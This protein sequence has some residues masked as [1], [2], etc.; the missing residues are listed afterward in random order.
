MA[1]DRGVWI[2]RFLRLAIA[3]A[4]LTWLWL[5]TD[6]MRLRRVLAEADWL[7]AL[8]GVACFGP[9]PVMLAFRLKLLLGV[10]G[11]DLGLGQ[12]VR[13]TFAGNFIT[14]ALPLGTGGGDTVKAYIVAR[15]TP[16]KHEAVTAILFDR[17]IGVG[18]LLTLSGVMVLLDWDNPAFAQYGR[19]IALAILLLAGGLVVVFSHRARRLFRVE[20]FL[21]ALPFGAHLARMDR[22]V[23]AFRTRPR[24]VAACWVLTLILQLNSV[25]VMFLV[26]WALGLVG[27]SPDSAAAVYLAYTPICFLTGALPIGVMEVA[28]A[29]LLADAGALGTREAAVSLSFMGRIIQLIWSLPGGWFVLRSHPPTL[30]GRSPEV[31]EELVDDP[32]PQT[33]EAKTPFA[34]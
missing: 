31:V 20:R 26:G 8:V 23:L 1:S 27:E 17:L 11:I 4:A 14:H 13:A 34:S 7:L 2:S 12:V 6:W 9:A 30:A 28:F 21:A 19:P 24:T 22:A 10:Q 29:E 32:S 16:H 33:A 25:L 18:G 15:Q 3:A 5:D